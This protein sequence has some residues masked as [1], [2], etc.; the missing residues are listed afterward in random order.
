MNSTLYSIILDILV[1][2]II[3]SGVILGYKRGF[4]RTIFNILRYII[5]IVTSFFL[6]TIISKFIIVLI[7]PNILEYIQNKA[8]DIISSNSISTINDIYEKL[9][10]ISK[11]LQKIGDSGILDNVT[12]KISTV[13]T[14]NFILPALQLLIQGVICIILFFI[15]LF[16]SNFIIKK[17]TFVNKIPVVGRMNEILGLIAGFVN[18]FIILFILTSLV[19]FIIQI[20]ANQISIL[21]IKVIESSLLFEKLYNVVLLIL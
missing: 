1:V 6:S 20:S 15:M 16:L 19:H 5:S 11:Y 14:N 4:V 17:L 8:N 9:P 10:Y 7:Q 12:N 3:A 13:I 18:S 21:N 2:V